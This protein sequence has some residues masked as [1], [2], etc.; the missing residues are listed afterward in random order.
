MATAPESK[1]APTHLRQRRVQLENLP[2]A[3]HLAHANFA[4]Q[5]HGGGGE[6]LQSEAAVEVPLRAA[7]HVL[8][9]ELLRAEK[10]GNMNVFQLVF[11]FRRR[12][13]PL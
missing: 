5:I 7:P 8:K 10:R 13:K 11:R 3:L 9:G 12:W 1:G 6:A 2:L 4:G